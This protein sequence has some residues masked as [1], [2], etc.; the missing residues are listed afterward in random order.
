MSML[1]HT[2]TILKS[3]SFDKSL[4]SKELGKA[5]KWLKKD[6]LPL[7]KAW[8]AVHF[9]HEYIEIVQKYL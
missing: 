8:C 4:F 2:K 5:L 7:L 9:G 1:E 6:E 3:V